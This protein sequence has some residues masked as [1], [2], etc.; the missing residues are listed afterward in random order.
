MATV[1][2]VTCTSSLATDAV[3][4]WHWRIPESN[5]STEIAAVISALDTFYE[6]I[7]ANL[8]PATITIGTRVAT[9]DKN[10]N[11]EVPH[12]S[13]TTV[14]SGAST[15]MLAASAVIGHRA[16]LIG[17]RYRGRKYIG[18]L[19]SGSI[20]SNGRLLDAT[21][22]SSLLSALTTLGTTTTAGIEMGVWSRKFSSFTPSTV[23]SVAE[24]LGV[25]RR[26][27]Q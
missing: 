24:T 26:R 27:L 20:Q 9:V 12:S 22:R 15:G 8:A 2:E 13:L 4:V 23:F 14:T 5:V 21:F 11:E 7:D 16:A 6:A 10:P 1:V 18:P 25:Q 3:N 17:G 19:T